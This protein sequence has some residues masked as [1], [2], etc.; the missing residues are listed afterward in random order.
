MGSTRLYCASHSASMSLRRVIAHSRRLT[1]LAYFL[2]VFSQGPHHWSQAWKEELQAQHQ[3]RPPASLFSCSAASRPLAYGP[4]SWM[5]RAEE[6]AAAARRRGGRV[7]GAEDGN[8][9]RACESF[10]RGFSSRR[11][12]SGGDR[13]WLRASSTG[14]TTARMLEGRAAGGS[15][16]RP[17]LEASP[18]PPSCLVRT[19]RLFALSSLPRPSPRRPCR[20]RRPSRLGLCSP[21][22]L[23][24]C[25]LPAYRPWSSGS[26]CWLGRFLGEN[27]HD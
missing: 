21:F 24:R 19:L 20:P 17:R 26:P 15:Q 9:R 12:Q 6:E 22:G 27:R 5:G 13:N 25:S 14:Q 11:G 7:H 8:R 10:Q 4:G 3:V 18:P 1:A 16:P 23:R 2:S